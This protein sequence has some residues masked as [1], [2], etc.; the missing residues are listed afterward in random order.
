MLDEIRKKQQNK[1]D[2]LYQESAEGI[3]SD[4]VFFKLFKQFFGAL[5]LTFVK[6]AILKRLIERELKRVR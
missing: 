3:V 1:L 4:A 2:I 5:R 6:F